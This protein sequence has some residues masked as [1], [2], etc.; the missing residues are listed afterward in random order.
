MHHNN[1]HPCRSLVPMRRFPTFA[2]RET[3]SLGQQMLE[4]WE[5]IYTQIGLPHPFVRLFIGYQTLNLGGGR[6]DRYVGKV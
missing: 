5:Q 2:V 4:R 6:R 3:Q 1:A